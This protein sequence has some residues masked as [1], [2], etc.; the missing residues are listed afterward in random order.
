[1]KRISHK[2]LDKY[3]IQLHPFRM[4]NWTSNDLG[5]NKLTDDS[6]VLIKQ[7]HVDAL[8]VLQ[9]KG[10]AEG[11]EEICVLVLGWLPGPH[12]CKMNQ[13]NESILMF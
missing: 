4:E 2:W 6:K 10:E 8:Q 1:M 5:H 12:H 7:A 3:V 13:F 9:F 11:D